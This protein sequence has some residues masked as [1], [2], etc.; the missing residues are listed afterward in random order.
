MSLMAQTDI[1]VYPSMYPE[2]LPTSILEAGLLKSTIIATDRGGTVEVIN[3]SDL[4]IIIEENVDSLAA[5]LKDLV[6]DS[7]KRIRLQETIQKRV[8]QEFTW[9]ETARKLRLYLQSL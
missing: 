2:G 4:G 5:A 7:D 1:F 3:N 9:S 6:T 8:L